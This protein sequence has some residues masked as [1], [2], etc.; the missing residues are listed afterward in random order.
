MGIRYKD[1]YKIEGMKTNGLHVAAAGEAP[2]ITVGRDGNIMISGRFL[3]NNTPDS[4]DCLL[5]RVTGYFSDP[6]EV[7]TLN[8]HIEYLEAVKSPLIISAIRKLMQARSTDNHLV[9]NW[10]YE[11]GDDDMLEQG[12]YISWAAG[13]P[14]NYIMIPA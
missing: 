12:E 7:T 9:V 4:P 5:K 14:F 10:F 6:A 13:Q 2:G 11:E 8:L 3:R 1:R